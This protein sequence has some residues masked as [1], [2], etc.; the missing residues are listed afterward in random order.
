MVETGARLQITPYGAPAL[1]ALEAMVAVRKAGDPLRP[2]TVVMPSSLAALTVRRSLARDGLVATEFLTLPALAPRVAAQRL[3][4]GAARPLSALEA[5]LTVRAVLADTPSRLSELRHHP[6]TLAA[7]VDTF[8]ELRAL[9]A[10]ELAALA[11][12]SH[13]AAE[14]VDLYRAYRRAVGERADDHDALVAAAAAV[15]DDDHLRDEIGD[16]VLHLPRRLG[17]AELDLLAAFA[18]R[19]RL[20]AIVGDSTIADQLSPLLGAAATP[21]DAAASAAVEPCIICAPDPAE[22]AR[23][24]VRIVL[25]HLEAG[26]PADRIAIVS[27]VAQPYSLL[28]HEELDA[29]GIEHSAPAP[30]RLAQSIAGRS[31]L[32]LLRWPINGHRRDELMRLLRSAPIRDPAGGATRPDR[33][34]RV[35][36]N[37]GVVGG[38]DQWHRRLDEAARSRLERVKATLSGAAE[39]TLPLDGEPVE[40]DARA[41]EIDALRSFVDRLAAATDPTDKRGWRSLSRWAETLLVRHIG[42]EGAALSW[43]DADQRARAA[44]IDLLQQLGALDGLGPEPDVETFI[45]LL[46]HELDRPAGRVGRFGRGVF[47]GRLVDAVGAD[48]DLVIVLGAAEGMFPPRSRDDALLPER[49]RRAAGGALRAR[50]ATYEE[51]ERDA[52]AV[53]A[54]A[55]N[56]VLTYPA[57]DPRGQRQLQPSAFVLHQAGERVHVDSF[58][59]WLASGRAAATPSEFDLRELLRARAAGHPVDALPIAATAGIDRGLTAAAARADGAFGEWSGL[60]GRWPHLADDLQHPRSPTGLQQWATCPFSY[61]LGRVLGL[62]ELEDPGDAETITPMDRGSLVHA[63]LEQFFRQRLGRDV[64]AEWMPADYDELL[65]V[66]DDIEGVF[67]ARGLTGRPLLWKAEWAALRRHLRKILDADGSDPRLVGVAPAEVELAFGFEGE[68]TPPVQIDLGEGRVLNFGGRVDRI[69]R[70]PDGKRLVVLDYKTGSAYHYAVIDAD[71]QDHDIVARG[72]LLQLPI[73]ALAARAQFP[74][75]ET[76]EAYYWFIGQRGGI[77]MK[78]GPVDDDARDRFQSVVGTIVEGIEDGLF[79]A[80]PGPDE[81]RPNIGPTHSN[82]LYCEFDGLCSSTRGEQWLSVRTRPEIGEYVELAE[83]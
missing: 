68:P 81:W 45:R 37:A 5:R 48:L 7:L 25:E 27:R 18:G 31:L 72:Q 56:A 70:S 39:P 53:L 34:D 40:A 50:G 23:V 12:G 71:H 29:A 24:A 67:R 44:V 9:T 8:A 73:Y 83:G 38:L 54:A 42:N 47:V 65:A 26:V 20:A 46:A 63:V 74:D 21:T 36:R 19:D 78:G 79:P 41:A 51:E 55:S 15:R 13:R 2:V 66:A 62:R 60:V 3:A 75:A 4:A 82:C 33:W 16:V 61:F 57:S 22:E 69:D 76:A 35:A 28:V 80:R 58:E 52:R 59:W 14:V 49:E 1:R 17:R 11:A 64:D 77:Q 43:S 30:V 10:S 32:G 6:E